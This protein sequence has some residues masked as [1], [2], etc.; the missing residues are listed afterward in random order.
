MGKENQSSSMEMTAP[1]QLSTDQGVQIQCVDTSALNF[2]RCSR[3]HKEQAYAQV[4]L[5]TGSWRVD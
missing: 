5:L 1:A 2:L 4:D 3:K